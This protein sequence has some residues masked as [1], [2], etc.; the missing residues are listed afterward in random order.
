[1]CE[2]GKNEMDHIYH[3][4]NTGVALHARRRGNGTNRAEQ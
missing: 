3:L 2:I 4:V 1:M